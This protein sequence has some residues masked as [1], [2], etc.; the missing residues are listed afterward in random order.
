MNTKRKNKSVKTAAKQP[1]MIV[2]KIVSEFKDRT[3]AEIRKWR[4]ALELAGDI[5]TPRLYLIQDL[6]DNL[7]DDGH[8]ISQVEL[9][10][11]A[12]LC[13]PF[14]IIDRATGE[15]NEEKTKL[16]K[17]EWFYN[18]M[19]D[20]LES[21]YYGYTL[22]ELSDP[23]TMQFSLVPRRN[24]VPLFSMVL[25]EVNA[26]TGISYATGYENSLIHVGKPSDI[27]LMANICGQL[28]WKR[29]AQQSWAD[30][31]EKY[32]QPLLTATTNKTSQGDID[33]IET[34]LSA[35]GEAAQAVLPEG[36]TI[37]IKPFAGSD[38]YQVYDKQIERINTEIGKPITGGTMISDNGASRSQS[39]VHERNLDEKI[40]AADQRIVTFTVNGQLLRIMQAVGWDVNPETDEFIFDTSVKLA[41]KDYFEIVT[42]LLDKG[43]PIPTKWISKTF[44]IPITG[45]P[46]APVQTALPTGNKSEGKPGGF[47]ANFQ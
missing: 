11:A 36:T 38:A 13:S 20:V 17:T 23:V 7:K 10:K 42:R 8:F 32:G 25:P 29:N 44:N 37:D 9:R 45:D 31:S 22:L 14:S 26:T 46:V 12:T 43:Y 1:D 4:Q 39:E 41:L 34:M 40:A 30:F 2:A 21:P 15:V 47:L 16:F 6:Y 24:L 18:F 5:N 28:I 33:K 19:E 27:G 35:L 3:R